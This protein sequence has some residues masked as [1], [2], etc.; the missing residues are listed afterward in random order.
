[1]CVSGL[2]NTQ[3]PVSVNVKTIEQFWFY[4][5]RLKQRPIHFGDLNLSLLQ[6]R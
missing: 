5:K 1:M 2:E 6:Q 4:L 3:I